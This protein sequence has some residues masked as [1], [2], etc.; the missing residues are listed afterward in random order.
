[1]DSK[2]VQ[3]SFLDVGTVDIYCHLEKNRKIIL[4]VD[5]THT[6]VPIS[7]TEFFPLTEILSVGEYN[8]SSL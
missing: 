4:S 2:Y 5:T 6:R 1:M 3:I 7:Q 8:L